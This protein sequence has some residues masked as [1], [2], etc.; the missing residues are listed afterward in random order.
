MIAGCRIGVLSIVAMAV[1]TSAASAQSL[2]DR[3]E[4]VRRQRQAQQAQQRTEARQS[5][6]ARVTL[7]DRLDG[8]P[9][10]EAIEYLANAGD[11]PILVDWDRLAEMGIDPQ[12]EVR[13]VGRGLTLG[14]ALK[15]VMTQIEGIEE[16]VLEKNPYYVRV[17]TKTQANRNPELRIYPIGDLLVQ[18]PH[19]EG[20]PELDLQNLSQI[21]GGTGG[22]GGSGGLGGGGGQSIFEDNNRSQDDRGGGYG[23]DGMGT[24]RQRALELA[25]LVRNTVEPDIWRVNGGSYGSVQVYGDN[26]VVRAPQYVHEQISS[27]AITGPARAGSSGAS[28]QSSDDDASANNTRRNNRTIRTG[29]RRNTNRRAPNGSRGSYGAPGRRTSDGTAAVAEPRR[30]RRR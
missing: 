21:T 15:M 5:A 17:L 7:G 24:K 1:V 9:A 20:A 14:R 29:A 19:Y 3:I 28:A 11:L 2:S 12:Q 4:Q 18:I 6:S 16:L 8:V 13:V 10:R 25:D 26:L 23:D 27:H 22:G 30:Q